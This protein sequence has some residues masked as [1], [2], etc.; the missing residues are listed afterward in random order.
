M[1]KHSSYV[2]LRNLFAFKGIALIL[3]KG[4]T[5]RITYNKYTITIH[6]PMHDKTNKMTY[7]RSED[8]DQ[9]MISLHSVLSG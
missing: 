2:K 8:S 7:S 6:E 3:V 9:A 5:P 1:L 4:V